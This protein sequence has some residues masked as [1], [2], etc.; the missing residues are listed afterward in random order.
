MEFQ[1]I[2]RPPQSFQQGLAG[3]DIQAICRRVY[4]GDAE[5]VS[6][7]E[8][9]GGRYNNTY[10]VVVTGR[11]Q[12][13]VLRVAPPPDRQFRSEHQLMRNEFASI[14]WLS[15]LAPLMPQVI[16]ADWSH[17]V[18]GRDHMVQS[19]LDGVPAPDRLGDYPRST[20][21]GFYRHSGAIAR[22]VHTTTGAAFGPLAGP[23]RATWSQAVLASLRDIATDLDSVGVDAADLRKVTALAEQH[24]AVVDEIDEPHLLGGDRRPRHRDVHPAGRDHRGEPPCPSRC[25]SVT[26]HRMVGRRP[27][28]M[29]WTTSCAT[30]GVRWSSAIRT[31]CVWIP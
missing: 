25:T 14:P 8:L 28:W 17:T 21:P 27:W 30:A 16:A 15:V 20:W 31:G 6:A 22:A 12:P 5:V 11:P 13:V 3:E 24:S 10:L 29:C 9:G 2:E 1:A 7:M 26:R 19:F 23:C 18:V 4:G